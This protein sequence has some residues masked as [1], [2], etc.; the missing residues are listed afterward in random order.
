M[1][2]E[3]NIYE[4]LDHLQTRKALYLGNDYNFKCLESFVTGFTIAATDQQMES[5]QYPS[6]H[7]F[8]SWIIGHLKKNFGSSFGWHWQIHNRN[9]TNDENAFKEFFEFLEK[10]KNSE[11]K[12]KMFV[13]N[14][15]AEE[16]YLNSGVK[17]SRIVDG[18]STP[19]T[20]VPSKIIWTTIA[21]S[22]TV[23]YDYLDKNG[24]V[25][26]S[27]WE[28]NEKELLNKFKREFGSLDINWTN[29]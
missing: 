5:S 25:L 24:N 23:W 1:K 17:K 19:I 22:K 4:I 10:F 18:N 11:V 8:N 6:F 28:I 29:L 15:N 14:K 26:E 12:K 27:S 2:K 9:P 13:I 3:I 16:N 20:E 21:N 7:F